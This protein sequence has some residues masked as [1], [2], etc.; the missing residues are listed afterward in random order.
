M[1]GIHGD[2]NLSH[3]VATTIRRTMAAAAAES[4][5]RA[6]SNHDASRDLLTPACRCST[7]ATKSASRR[8]AAG[9]GHELVGLAG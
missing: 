1:T 8:C 2:I 6:E 3:E 4:F 9:V 5:L 7:R